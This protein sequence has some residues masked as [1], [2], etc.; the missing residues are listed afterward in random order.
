MTNLEYITQ[1][2]EF[3][4]G[5]LT[6]LIHE[7]NMECMRKMDSAGVECELYELDTD[8]QIQEHLRWL[9]SEVEQ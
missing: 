7:K 8:L 6:G 1:S 2:P 3:L 9:E 4:A 5:V